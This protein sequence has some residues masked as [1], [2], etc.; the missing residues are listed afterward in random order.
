MDNMEASCVFYVNVGI[1]TY[2]EQGTIS[3]LTVNKMGIVRL[4]V[5]HD[6][7]VSVSFMYYPVDYWRQTSAE[8]HSLKQYT[9]YSGQPS[10]FSSHTLQFTPVNKPTTSD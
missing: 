1:F 9:I 7:I 2:L 3:L 5:Q 10:D 4:T 8:V 6:L